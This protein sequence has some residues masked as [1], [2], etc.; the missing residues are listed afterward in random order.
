MRLLVDLEEE[1]EE[2]EERGEGIIVV[3]A[4]MR[5]RKSEGEGDEGWTEG[6][7]IPP[8]I[9]SRGIREEYMAMGMSMMR[10]NCWGVMTMM[11][12]KEVMAAGCKDIH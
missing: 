5:M 8:G 12:R 3:S 11:K 1:E 7:G 10:G 6:G 9:H 2:G 4:G